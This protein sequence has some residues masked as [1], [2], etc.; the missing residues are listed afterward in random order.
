M[1]SHF[2]NLFHFLITLADQKTLWKLLLGLETDS[3]WV[4][5]LLTYIIKTWTGTVYVL[6]AVS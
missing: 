6:Y 1:T 4:I 5:V 2:I 3:N